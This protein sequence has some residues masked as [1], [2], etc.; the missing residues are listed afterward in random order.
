MWREIIFWNLG[1]K[2]CLQMALDLKW[3]HWSVTTLTAFKKSMTFDSQQL[4][5][6]IPKFWSGNWLWFL[7]HLSRVWSTPSQKIGKSSG[8]G[9]RYL[10]CPFTANND[11][12][13]KAL[14]GYTMIGM[15]FFVW[16][17]HFKMCDKYL[18]MHQVCD[19]LGLIGVGGMGAIVVEAGQ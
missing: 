4:S 18:M 3:A 11:R 7:Y 15:A 9:S 12:M 17:G 5:L 10:L 14:W 13:S 19:C 1:Q 6:K 16:M 2:L 8:A